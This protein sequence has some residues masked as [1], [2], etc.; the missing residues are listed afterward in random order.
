[1]PMLRQMGADRCA[2]SRRS[3][4]N[5]PECVSRL[6]HGLLLC[7]EAGGLQVWCSNKAVVVKGRAGYQMSRLLA[8]SCHRCRYLGVGLGLVPEA[9]ATSDSLW[10]GTSLQTHDRIP[11]LL[12]PPY[13]LRRPRRHARI[14]ACPGHTIANLHRDACPRSQTTAQTPRQP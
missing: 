6:T 11:P 9:T 14:I 8:A 2:T 1:V 5:V 12:S 4:Q 13:A 3:G 7:W 10:A